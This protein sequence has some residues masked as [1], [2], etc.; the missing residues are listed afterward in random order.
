MCT[1]SLGRGEVIVDLLPNGSVALANR[2]GAVNRVTRV[3]VRRVLDAAGT[4]FERLAT[5]WEEMHA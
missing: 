1:A 3:E 5:A 4:A 2:H